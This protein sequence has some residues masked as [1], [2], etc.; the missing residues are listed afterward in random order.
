MRHARARVGL[1]RAPRRWWGPVFALL[2]ALASLL[3]DTGSAVMGAHA[4]GGPL[5]SLDRAASVT[6][7]A[8]PEARAT[9]AVPAA[10]SAARSVP[11]SR[12]IEIERERPAFLSDRGSG[13]CRERLPSAVPAVDGLGCEASQPL[14][15]V[16][17]QFPRV[18]PVPPVAVAWLRAPSG[19][20]VPD[21]SDADPRPL[22]RPPST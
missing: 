11:P 5:A 3:L 19:R 1:L 13:Q 22:L 9:V 17:E 21:P 15:D 4:V 8:T 14:A 20:N 18:V 12:E 16:P 7:P 10:K 2:L 6:A